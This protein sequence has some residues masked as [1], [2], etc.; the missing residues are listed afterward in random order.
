MDDYCNS[1]RRPSTQKS[2]I[3]DLVKSDAPPHF[4]ARPGQIEKNL[5][6]KEGCPDIPTFA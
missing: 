3:F 4:L 2:K 1:A 5:G 6:K